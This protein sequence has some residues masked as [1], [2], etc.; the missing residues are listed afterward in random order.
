MSQNDGAEKKKMQHDTK[1][2]QKYFNI[3]DLERNCS[4]NF[5]PSPTAPQ[6]GA[7]FF[8]TPNLRCI[9]GG[10]VK[11]RRFLGDFFQCHC[12]NMW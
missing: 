3:A 10:P 8:M 11:G 2:Y 1:H 6:L 12:G 9:S 5:P 7:P 4:H